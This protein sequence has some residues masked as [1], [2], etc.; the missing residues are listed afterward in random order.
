[1]ADG[2]V[3][4]KVEVDDKEV[5]KQLNAV[6]SKIKESS[7]ETSDKQKKDYK[8]TSKEFKKQS[9]E[10]VKENKN[11][12]K[13]ITD[14]SSGTAGTLKEVFV[15]AADEI[16]LSFSNLTKAGIIGGLAGLSAKAVS[17]A[18]DFD[19]AMNQFVASTGVANE[20]LKDYENILK[21]LC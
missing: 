10:V 20:K 16:G 2:D 1:M 3:V 15:N 8:E 14:G 6:N 11:T 19:K 12:N 4:Y 21:C 13:S 18:V 7:Q 17:G 5:D 9:N